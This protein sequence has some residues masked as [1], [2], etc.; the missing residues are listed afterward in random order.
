MGISPLC[1]R[2][3]CGTQAAWKAGTAGTAPAASGAEVSVTGRGKVV[4]VMFGELME[5]FTDRKKDRPAVVPGN[6]GGIG[7]FLG[8]VWRRTALKR[9]F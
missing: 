1:A 4:T 8:T 7:G 2:T 9:D 6:G 3:N 5:S